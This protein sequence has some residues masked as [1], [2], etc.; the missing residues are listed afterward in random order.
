VV[1]EKPM[2]KPRS[3][4]GL[5]FA[6]LFFLA[7]G[8]FFAWLEGPLLLRDIGIGDNIE[9]A[10]QA[11]MVEGRC[12]VRLVLHMCDIKL[13]RTGRGA[14]QPSELHYL[15]VDMPFTEHRVRL[16]S[17]KADRSIVTTDIGQQMLWNR[18]I[19]FGFVM[20]FC[21]SPL[22]LVPLRLARRT[23]AASGTPAS[24]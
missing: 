16:M 20:A 1:E 4:T 8:S 19:T 24:G 9:A 5:V 2:A 3:V 12:R 7:G 23:R 10:T 18:A 6:S 22:V 13:D 21:F 15:F 11:R 17:A 14:T